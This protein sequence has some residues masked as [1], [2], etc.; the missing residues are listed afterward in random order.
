M[1]LQV[2][3][4][5]IKSDDLNSTQ[6]MEKR[7]D[8]LTSDLHMITVARTLTPQINVLKSLNKE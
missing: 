5:S 4:F 6:R 3:A 1:T 8:S 2:R 7:T